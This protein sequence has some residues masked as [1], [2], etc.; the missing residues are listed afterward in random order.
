MSEGQVSK[1]EIIETV[2][3]IDGL[4]KK[5]KREQRKQKVIEVTS[6]TI[7]V[8]ELGTWK[9]YKKLK[10]KHAIFYFNPTMV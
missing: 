7:N 4:T 2:Q 6:K 3:I 5:I 8:V 10:E 9:L 1:E